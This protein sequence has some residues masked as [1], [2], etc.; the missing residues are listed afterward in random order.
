[1]APSLPSQPCNTEETVTQNK[2]Y[3]ETDK[4]F[5]ELVQTLPKDQGWMIPTLVQ[6]QGFWYPPISVFKGVLLM[7]NHFRSRPNDIFMAS[8]LKSGTTWLKAI[9]FATM[10]RDEFEFATHPLLTTGPHDCFPFLDS[11][12][13][14]SDVEALPSPRLFATHSAYSILPKSITDSDCKIVYISRNP[15]D[16]F[17]SQYLFV[18]KLR[19]QMLPPLTM[20]E[21]FEL[22]C[23]GVSEYGPFFDHVLGYWKASLEFPEKILFLK[24]EEMKKEP[25]RHIKK[26]AEFLGKPFSEEE[27]K[28]GVIEQVVKLCSFDNLTSLEVNKSG[29]S[30]FIPE[31]VVHNTNFFRKG[32]VGDS[33][34]HLTPEMIARLDQITEEKLKGTGFTFGEAKKY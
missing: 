30:N 9:L 29:T 32:Q 4:Q 31:M 10:K 13:C 6:Y 5:F 28:D 7:Q 21:A 20:E 26:L 1:M 17:V 8:F 34:N 11:Y 27:E 18:Q 33:K 2:V 16:V 19:P 24:Y 12:I 23:R 22:F 25:A 3:Q 14:D 15:K